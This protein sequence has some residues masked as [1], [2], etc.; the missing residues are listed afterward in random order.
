MMS[1]TWDDAPGGRD[2]HGTVRFRRA[3][4][5]GR[6][7]HD[8][9]ADTTGSRPCSTR[10]SSPTAARSLSGR[11]VPVTSW[12]RGRLRCSPTRTATRCIDSRPTRRTR[13]ANQDIPVR[14]YLSVEEIIG[15]ARKAKADAIYPGYGF[16]SENPRARRRLP[17]GRHHVHRAE[18]RGAG[19]DRE[20]GA[21]GGRRSGGRVAGVEFLRAVSGCRRAARRGRGDRVPGFRQGRRGWRWTRHATGG[22]ALRVAGVDRGGDARGRVGVRRS[23]RVPRTGGDRRP[24]TSRCRSWRTP[25][26]T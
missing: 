13:S 14:A 26:A 2:R 16:L 22:A 19:A 8:D 21:G 25:T 1:V 4:A 18:R 12:A 10:C 3:F 5:G 11:S 6:R 23:D 17:R 9:R 7:R 24:G 15:A 20:Q